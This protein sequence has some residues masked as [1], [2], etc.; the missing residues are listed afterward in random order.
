MGCQPTLWVIKKTV[1]PMAV[2]RSL[3]RY[4]KEWETFKCC[5]LRFISKNVALR[6]CSSGEKSGYIYTLAPS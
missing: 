3:A 1:S 4:N 5:R 2:T 6:L